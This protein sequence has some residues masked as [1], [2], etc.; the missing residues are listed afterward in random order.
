MTDEAATPRKSN[1]KS[2]SSAAA[3][4]DTSVDEAAP[5]R[6]ATRT[7]PDARTAA[8]AAA[9]ARTARAAKTATGTAAKR[10][11]TAAASKAAST[12]SASKTAGTAKRSAATKSSATTTRAPAPRRARAAQPAPTEV[13]PVDEAEVDETKLDDAEG[14]PVEA[15]DVPGDDE[16][17]GVTTTEAPPAGSTEP[18]LVVTNLKAPPQPEPPATDDR[19]AGHERHWMVAAI[20]GGVAAVGL[21][22]ALVVTMVQPNNSSAQLNAQSSALNAARGYAVELAGYDYRHLDQ[23]FATVLSHS[24]PSFKQSFTRSSDALKSTL[25]KYHATAV[26]KVVAAGVVSSN[27][28]Q[29]VALVFLDQIV[30]NSN[31]KSQTTD[32][33]QIEITLVPSSNGWLINQVS[34]L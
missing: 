19:H 23:D 9:S 17:G 11:S 7:S 13:A 22:I 27:S 1:G 34:V 29:V 31:Q 24:T 25:I 5:K 8:G 4:G 10:S 26:A 21:L 6:R 32:R 28:S 20:I 3:G 30:N 16:P 33:S 12:T 18:E 14:E 2:R 15:W